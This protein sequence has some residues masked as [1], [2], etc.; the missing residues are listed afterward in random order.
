MIEII[1][2][3]ITELKG[4]L[5]IVVCVLLGQLT[6]NRFNGSR[7]K[8]VKGYSLVLAVALFSTLIHFGLKRV[9]FSEIRYLT[10]ILFGLSGDRLI[11]KWITTEVWNKYDFVSRKDKGGE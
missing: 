10:A 4:I 6:Y 2:P 8:D 11:K 9:P 1:L 3:Y 5:Q 7:R